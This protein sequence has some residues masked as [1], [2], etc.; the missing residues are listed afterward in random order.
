MIYAN[1][2][3]ATIRPSINAYDISFKGIHL[4][5]LLGID[6]GII[7]FELPYELLINYRFQGHKCP[8]KKEGLVITNECRYCIKGF[9]RRIKR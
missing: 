4:E 3:L 7:T 5:T 8:F 9:Y 6:I 2:R 1:R